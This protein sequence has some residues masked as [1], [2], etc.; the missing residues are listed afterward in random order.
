MSTAQILPRNQFGL[1]ERDM[2]TLHNIL[3]RYPDVQQVCIFGSRA[4]GTFKHG[5]DIDLAVMNPDVSDVTIRRIKTNCED[6]SLPYMVDILP[7]ATL[8]DNAV[9]DHLMRVGVLFL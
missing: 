5:S 8:T 9:K 3:R 4:K 6:S 2:T 1:T 7:F